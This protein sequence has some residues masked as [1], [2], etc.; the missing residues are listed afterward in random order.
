MNGTPIA[1]QLRGSIDKWDNM[2]LNR[3]P[4]EMSG[5]WGSLDSFRM[6][7]GCQKGQGSIRE[8]GLW[9]PTPTSVQRRKTE[10]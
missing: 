5:D 10:G 3:V 4:F 7:A 2:K 1:Q 6:G 8:F 9:V